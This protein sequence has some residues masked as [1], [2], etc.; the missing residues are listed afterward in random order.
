MNAPHD[1]TAAPPPGPPD[2]AGP[3]GTDPAKV[4]DPAVEETG[5]GAVDAQAEPDR[6]EPDSAG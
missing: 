3:E 5:D 4:P 1:E 2:G 6:G